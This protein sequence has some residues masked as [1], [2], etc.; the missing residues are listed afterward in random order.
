M[1]VPVPEL[2]PARMA[3]APKTVTS[4]AVRLGVFG[5]RAFCER[6]VSSVSVRDGNGVGVDWVEVGRQWSARPSWLIKFPANRK[7]IY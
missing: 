3:A 4:D 5:E 2:Q 6:I 1:I 7:E